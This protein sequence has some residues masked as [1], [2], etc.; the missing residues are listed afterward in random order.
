MKI[1]VFGAS[2][3]KLD[4]LYYEQARLFGRLIGAHGHTLVF[5][6]GKGGVMGQ[7]ALG[8]AE[9]GGEIIGIAP[10]FFDEPEILYK[11]SGEL[12][13]T[14]TMDERKQ[15][16]WEKSD[17]FA[18]LAGGIGTYDEL[19]ACITLKQ[20]GRHSK[21]IALLNT[22]DCYEPF[23]SLIEHGISERF[24]S[25]TCRGLFTVCSTASELIEHLEN[26]KALSGNIN[27]LCDYT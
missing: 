27:R 24:I 17:A 22:K 6:G 19:F 11:D 8:A 1:C 18:A 16:M 4:A 5:G 3:D 20:L 13:L 23:R 12:I 25:S 10:K 7:C 21:P 15:L 2:S 9:T 14:E 26:D